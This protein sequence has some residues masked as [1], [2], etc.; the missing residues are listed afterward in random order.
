F[1]PPLAGW[2]LPFA[3]SYHLIAFNSLRM[4]TFLQRTFTSLVHAHAGRTQTRQ[5]GR[6]QARAYYAGVSAQNMEMKKSNKV[7]GFSKVEEI[8]IAL[9]MLF[10]FGPQFLA[11]FA[12]EFPFV[13]VI[14]E[15]SN[16]YLYLFSLAVIGFVI[17]ELIAR[18]FEK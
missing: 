11:A 18:M 1:R 7:K 8:E 9:A 5:L 14:T 6:S 2:P 16:Y 12:P 15:G 10:M 3:S 13:Q 4:V 17:H